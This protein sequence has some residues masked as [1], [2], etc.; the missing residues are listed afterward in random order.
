MKIIYPL[1]IVLFSSITTFSQ[2][3]NSYAKVTA[4]TNADRKSVV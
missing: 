1:V 2:V 4:L 3:V